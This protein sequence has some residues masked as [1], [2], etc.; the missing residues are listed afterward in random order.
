[1]KP[2]LRYALLLLLAAA[3]LVG[4]GSIKPAPLVVGACLF[5]AHGIVSL[6]TRSEER[7][8]ARDLLSAALLLGCFEV[9]AM[10]LT[11]SLAMVLAPPVTS[12]GHHV[13]PMGQVLV[14]IA[15]GGV[16]GVV[17]TF[18]ALRPRWRDRRL[19]RLLLHAVG[20]VVIVAA[21]VAWVRE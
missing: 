6:V 19:E 18:L 15:G 5:A 7:S 17:L 4:V 2:P 16:V 14:G 21:V 12:D 1:M 11:T 8:T 9:S 3:P 20:A 13:M 10:F